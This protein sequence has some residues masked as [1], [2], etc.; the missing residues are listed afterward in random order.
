MINSHRYGTEK[1]VVKQPSR[2]N[3]CC[4]AESLE[5][6]RR[7]RRT[8]VR[9]ARSETITHRQPMANSRCS[10]HR[11][12]ASER[13]ASSGLPIAAFAETRRSRDATD[14]LERPVPLSA[15]P[16]WRYNRRHLTRSFEE[17]PISCPS[18]LRVTVFCSERERPFF[19]P[20]PAIRF[21]ERAEGVKGP[22]R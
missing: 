20:S 18:S 7:S 11:R 9:A 15:R 12:H 8:D 22:K 19:V 3:H 4:A 1:A 21:P 14:S 16:A 13:R 2:D 5:G 10:Y 17:R 6:P